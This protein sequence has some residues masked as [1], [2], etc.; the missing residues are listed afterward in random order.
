[1]ATVVSFHAHPDDESIQ[2]GGTLCKA[3]R[4]GHRVVLVFAT[5]GEH[6]EVEDGF[7]AA[8]ETL[9]ERREAETV[10]S[11]EVL[12]AQRVAFLDYVDS[13]MDGTPENDAAESFW[14][15]PLE[16]AAG[17]LAALLAEE[18]ADVL[19]IYDDHGGYGHPDH[20]QVHRVGV[21][22]A[23]LA[24]TPRVAEATMNR[25]QIR[26]LRELIRDAEGE[27]QPDGSAEDDAGVEVPDVTA[28][29]TFGSAESEITTRVDVRGFLAEKRASMAAHAS[30][31]AESSFFLSIPDEVFAEAFG[32]EWFIRHDVEPGGEMG[33]DL[34]AGL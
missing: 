6:G 29:P 22:A 31:I 28:S 18:R 15:A 26:R 8:G 21:R 3:A 24:G 2:T 4:A 16:E 34:L 13:G 30:Q 7:L 19:T 1:V 20:I 17:R 25:D 5:R 11:A 14:Q 33:D 23:E 9:A 12:G 32:D 27:P 10:R